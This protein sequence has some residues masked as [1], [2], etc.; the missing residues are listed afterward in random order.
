MGNIDSQLSQAYELIESD[1]ALEAQAIL[2]P[3]LNEEPDN[4]DLWWLY[5]HAVD[6]ETEAQRALN[7]VLRINP[8]YDGAQP[9]LAEFRQNKGQIAP[10]SARLAEDDL[11]ADEDD[12][13]FLDL[14]DDFDDLDEGSDSPG[15]STVESSGSNR[16]GLIGVLLV[17][18]FLIILILVVL[19]IKP[20][21]SDDD[22]ESV[23]DN[24]TSAPVATEVDLSADATEE[25]IA[26]AEDTEMGG[27]DATQESQVT[28]SGVATSADYSDVLNGL[29]NLNVIAD[30]TQI[31]D[32]SLG[33][34]LLIAVCTSAGETL[35]QDLTEGMRTIAGLTANISED[36]VGFRLIDCENNDAVLN[37]IAAPTES[38]AAFND[39]A[40]DEDNFQ[41]TWQAVG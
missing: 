17:I 33:S 24:P 4:A 27:G 23:A 10:L 3:L 26:T 18:I 20:F 19:V 25:M 9:L 21:S 5:A 32:T 7:N 16:R 8:D 13:D 6:D 35:R 41:A 30:D 22:G 14:D 28:I 37:V 12:D 15:K 40:L 29:S 38:A 36:A 39:G 2:K 31:V 34:T 1:R 11:F